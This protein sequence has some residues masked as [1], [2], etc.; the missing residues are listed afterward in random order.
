MSDL[1]LAIEEATSER[2]SDLLAVFGRQG[3]YAGCWCMYWR[4][5]RS[6]FGRMGVK[7]RREALKDLTARETPPGILYYDASAEDAPTPFG[8]CSLGPREDF[9]VL[10][11]SPVLK[12]VDDLPTWSLIC[13]YM[14]SEYQ[15]K[16]LFRSLAALAI[17]HAREKGAPRL[18]AYPNEDHTYGAFAYMGNSEVYRSLGFREIARRKTNR[19]ILRLEWTAQ[20]RVTA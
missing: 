13:F 12:P 20:P 4:V 14:R 10:R 6:E 3:A 15:G 9:S 11:R 5:K 17:K 7:G 19:P 8:W 18:E 16:G 1:K 2:W